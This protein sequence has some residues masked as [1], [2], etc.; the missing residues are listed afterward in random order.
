MLKKPGDWP[1]ASRQSYFLNLTTS[2]GV[3][4]I[5]LSHR[6]KEPSGLDGHRQLVNI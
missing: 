6:G 4:L 3:N 2:I 5:F 1:S